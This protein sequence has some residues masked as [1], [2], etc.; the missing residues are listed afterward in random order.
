MA[1][2]MKLWKKVLLW[3]AGAALLVICVLFA[4]VFRS[5][6]PTTGPPIGKYP[7]P[8]T[9]LIVMDIQEDY[10][11]P[12]AKKPYRDGDQIV[13]VSNALLAQAQ[14]K[15][16]V[17]VYIQSVISNRILSAFMGGINAPGSPGT[18]MDRR[19]IKVPGAMTF[20]K[21]QS[22]AFS[23]TEF[24][25]YLRKNNVDEVL[26]TGLDGAYCVNAT[27]RGALNR[28]YKV[29]LFQDGIATESGKSIE[30]LAQSWREAGAL[31]KTGTE[32]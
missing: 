16:V 28:G 15:G 30:K 20:T 25:G 3:M 2:E 9:A 13:K 26:I 17:V 24:D 7:A 22:D 10:T 18:E 29:T 32:M 19:L 31:V 1:A 5:M 6:R 14:A 21:N 23:N 8:R 11:G 4:L 12:Q 27:A